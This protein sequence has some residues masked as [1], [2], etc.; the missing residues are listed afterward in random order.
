M[1]DV[2]NLSGQQGEVAHLRLQRE[3]GGKGEKLRRA[4]TGIVEQD[5]GATGA[6]EVT[7][8]NVPVPIEAG[9]RLVMVDQQAAGEIHD[10]R[11]ASRAVI[12]EETIAVGIVKTANVD[13]P[14]VVHQGILLLL[15]NTEIA[16]EADQHDI[17][18]QSQAL[19]IDTRAP[20]QILARYWFLWRIEPGSS[21]KQCL[22]SCRGR[23]GIGWTG[24]W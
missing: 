7:G 10:T 21:G 8:V 4:R 19:C 23:V 6:I 1:P 20:A 16:F 15:I 3:V 13:L 9:E 22:R 18:S 17:G 12:E 5:L 24:S 11:L 14:G 2:E